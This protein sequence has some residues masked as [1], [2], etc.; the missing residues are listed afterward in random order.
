M[1]ARKSLNARL[2]GVAET[3]YRYDPAA[4]PRDR[5]KLPRD[6]AVETKAG[7]LKKPVI[8]PK[9]YGP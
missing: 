5:S 7:D 6:P 3:Y 4:M 2:V 1:V 9:P 8:K